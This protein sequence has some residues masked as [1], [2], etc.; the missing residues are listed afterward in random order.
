[1]MEY[2]DGPPMNL[3]RPETYKNVESNG[4]FDV[5][6]R[7]KVITYPVKIGS[8][9]DVG[10][11]SDRFLAMK[12]KY[13]ALIFLEE[14]IHRVG[15]GPHGVVGISGVIGRRLISRLTLELVPI[16][17]LPYRHT[18]LHDVIVRCK[19]RMRETKMPIYRFCHLDRTTRNL[20]ALLVISIGIV[21]LW[22]KP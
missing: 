14:S 15:I 8:T 11:T 10:Q 3:I 6:L 22:S 16:S 1:M 12:S 9:D 13:V 21:P 7:R 20:L 17:P 5:I 19:V 2:L 4:E 18:F